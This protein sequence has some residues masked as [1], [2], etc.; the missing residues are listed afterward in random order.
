VFWAALIGF[1][2]DF[3]LADDA[4]QEAFAIA[5]ERWPR[6]SAMPIKTAR[7]DGVEIAYETFPAVT[8][9][10]SGGDPTAVPAGDPLLLITGIGMHMLYRPDGFAPPWSTALCGRPL[11]QPRPRAVHPSHRR[12]YTNMLLVLLGGASVPYQLEDMADDAATVL[13]ALGWRSAHVLG[14]SLGSMVAKPSPSTIL[15]VCSLTLS[16]PRRRGGSAGR[17][18]PRPYGCCGRGSPPAACLAPAGSKSG[19]SRPAAC[20]LARL[21]PG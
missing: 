13:N 21:P 19:W 6:V 3:D 14:R 17:S 2:G 20:W 4:A 11:R 18:W 16:D 8:P 5:A 10:P 9:L 12:R 15:T 1:L 7:H